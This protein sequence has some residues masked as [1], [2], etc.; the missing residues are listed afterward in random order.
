MAEDSRS[1]GARVRMIRR[2]RGM[3]LEVA[4]GLAGMDKSYLS[5]L[6]HG[7]RQ[8]DRRGIIEDLADALG[9]SPRDLTGDVEMATDRRSLAAM[10]SLPSL[11]AALADITLDDVPDIATRPIAVLADIAAQAHRSADDIEFDLTGSQLGDLITELHVIAVTGAPADRRAALAVLVQTCDTAK[12]LALTLG[13]GELAVTASR[14]GWEAARILERPDLVGFTAMDRA[15]SLA[16][17]GARRHAGTILDRTLTEL[18]SYPGPTPADTTL[19]QARGMLHLSAAQLAARTGRDGDVEAHLDEAVSLA[20]FTGERNHMLRHFG[21]AN[22]AAWT[23]AVRVETETGPEESDRLRAT[24]IDLAVLGS[25]RRRSA[26]HFDLARA[27]AQAEGTRD[28][29]ALRHID[30]ADRIAPLRIRR[31]PLT[32]ELVAS[33]DRRAVTPSWELQSMKRRVGLV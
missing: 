22:V 30:Q 8:F 12:T 16:K 19:A 28:G 31:D 29:E 21:P 26:V 15:N 23:L 25:A 17:I 1:I 24:P 2:R 13:R 7:K 20:R 33:L 18:Q 32:R 4:A 3:T 9:C 11:V 27:Y 10:S 5:R 6:E 14:R